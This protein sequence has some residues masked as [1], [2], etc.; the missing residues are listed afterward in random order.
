[1]RK[2]LLIL[3]AVALLGA[4]A[5]GYYRYSQK[6]EPPTITTARVTRGDLSETVGATGTL[7]A[8]TTVQVG[9]QVS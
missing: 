5:Y 7:Q 8:V 4:G 2:T 9:T 6:P 3:V 1:M